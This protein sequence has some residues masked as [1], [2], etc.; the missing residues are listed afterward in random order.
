[1]SS[2][3]FIWFSFS[4]D[5]DC[6]VESV[7][8]VRRVYGQDVP[9]CI[10]DDAAAPVSPH[11]LQLVRPTLYERTRFDRGGN[12]RG[13][14]CITGMLDC[15]RRA[16]EITR[17]DW[18]SKIDCDT[19][20]I[21]PWIEDDLRWAYQGV[22]WGTQQLGAGLN[23]TLR[24]DVPLRILDRIA[25]RPGIFKEPD[26]PEDNTIA[27]LATVCIPGSTYIHDSAYDA[28]GTRLAAGW[29]YT[30]DSPSTFEDCRGHS[31]IT[32][33]NRYTMDNLTIEERNGS[34][35]RA[36]VAETMLQFNEWIR[37]NLD[38]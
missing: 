36:R 37:V 5:G 1:M 7:D 22:S 19:I 38:T 23:Y 32:F 29:M 30:Q 34:R 21:R 18:I 10:F 33:G 27:L 8:S 4:G 13:A 17:A 16:A 31:M 26:C 14:I 15:M 6:L 11:I 9:V 20:L 3:A 12:L 24:K 35:A 25:G 28:P 2:I